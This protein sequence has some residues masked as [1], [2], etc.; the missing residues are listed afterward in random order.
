MTPP[1]ISMES[2]DL[3]LMLVDAI[4]IA[5]WKECGRFHFTILMLTNMQSIKQNLI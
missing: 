3:L 4:N 5:N 2:V 1:D